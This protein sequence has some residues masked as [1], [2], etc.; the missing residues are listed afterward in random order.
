MSTIPVLLPRVV[1]GKEIFDA[2]NNAARQK[3]GEVTEH[4]EMEQLWSPPFGDKQIAGRSWLFADFSLELV[5]TKERTWRA[6]PK[7]IKETRSFRLVLETRLVE[8]C[9][10][11]VIELSLHERHRSAEGNL[12]FFDIDMDGPEYLMLNHEFVN[13]LRLFFENL[14]PKRVPTI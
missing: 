3:F 9:S 1:Q 13:F 2:L 14:T 5:Y 4:T 10:Y 8:N 12:T 6:K 7:Q 11:H